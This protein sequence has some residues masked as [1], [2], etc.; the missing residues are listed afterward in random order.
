MMVVR[1]DSLSRPLASTLARVTEDGPLRIDEYDLRVIPKQDRA[2]RSVLSTLEATAELL[3]EPDEFSMSDVARRS[4]VSK[5]TIYRYFPS[6]GHV[7]SALAVP[8]RRRALARVEEI[9]GNI[10]GPIEA[11]LAVNQLM[12]EVM[13][14]VE[15]D[16]LARSM[17]I[18]S[19]NRRHVGEIL[20]RT[21]FDIGEQAA[22]LLA[23]VLNTNRDQHVRRTAIGVQAARA[24]LELSTNLGPDERVRMIDEFRK[25]MFLAADVNLHRPDPVP[26]PE[27]VEDIAAVSTGDR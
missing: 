11:V 23:D 19:L 24:T 15:T 9:L 17:F 3:Q 6:L 14:F 10:N 7:V 25:M 5:G 18:T 12:D 22:D 4:G 26:L 8:Y 21:A 20:D 2:R 27:T 16:G 1:R 13:A